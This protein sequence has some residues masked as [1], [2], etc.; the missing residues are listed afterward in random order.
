VPSRV[1]AVLRVA[2][3]DSGH[4]HC[5]PNKPAVSFPSAYCLFADLLWAIVGRRL[6]IRNSRLA[7]TGKEGCF[8]QSTEFRSAKVTR[9]CGKKPDGLQAN[10][11][12]KAIV[13]DQPSR[14]GQFGDGAIGFAV[15]AVRGG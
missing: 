15:E 9:D 7:Q 2:A 4:D 5:V 10:D 12:R 11:A 8:K 1:K 13:A 3:G 14:R 6:Q